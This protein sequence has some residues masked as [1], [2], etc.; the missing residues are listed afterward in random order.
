MNQRACGIR[1][2]PCGERFSPAKGRHKIW[3]AAGGMPVQ[4]RAP[5]TD[6]G[7]RLVTRPM[8]AIV[9][10]GLSV[11]QEGAKP[12]PTAR[13]VPYGLSHKWLQRTHG[14]A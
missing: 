11:F 8:P 3:A 12:M 2:T 5:A 4:A 6:T 7:D 10:S 9:S 14:R 13:D 1:Y